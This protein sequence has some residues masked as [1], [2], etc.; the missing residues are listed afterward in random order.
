MSDKARK[1]DDSEKRFGVVAVQK[2][3][4]TPD[5]LLG[6]LKAQVQD[7]LAKGSHRLLGEILYEQGAMTWAQIGEVLETLGVLQHVFEP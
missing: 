4:V 5:E 7:D 6:V 1:M 2:G 3:F